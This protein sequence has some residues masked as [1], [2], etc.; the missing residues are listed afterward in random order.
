[1]GRRERERGAAF[2]REIAKALGCKRKLGQA[3][4]SG[5]DIDFPPF[6]IE[7]KR[8]RSLAVY[9]WLDQVDASLPL[10]EPG[11]PVVIA[12]GDNRPAVAVMYFDDFVRL[13]EAWRKT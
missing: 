12:R 1:M 5:N 8:R 3:R 2:E 9:Q 11:V 4:D 7:C 10:I 6:V 13:A